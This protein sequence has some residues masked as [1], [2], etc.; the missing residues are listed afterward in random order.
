VT[1]YFVG[2]QGC[3]EEFATRAGFSRTQLG[4]D[5][6]LATVPHGLKGRTWRDGDS[7]VTCKH[8]VEKCDETD[9]HRYAKV[10]DHLDRMQAHKDIGT[11]WRKVGHPSRAERGY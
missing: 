4:R 10:F 9:R 6:L 7:V 11:S 5:I 1:I 3:Y 2:V 8:C